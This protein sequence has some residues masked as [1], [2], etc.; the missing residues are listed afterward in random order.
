MSKK[1]NQILG[2]FNVAKETGK[3]ELKSKSE[4]VDLNLGRIQSE[5][6]QASKTFQLLEVQTKQSQ[7]KVQDLIADADEI[8]KEVQARKSKLQKALAEMED[9]GGRAY[10]EALKYEELA[11]KMME[12]D[13]DSKEPQR[14]ANEAMEI[15][16]DSLRR[17]DELEEIEQ[18]LSQILSNIKSI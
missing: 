5:Y 7:Q 8:K 2:K 10:D 18:D 6:Q 3:T 11:E 13:M 12:M 9:I 16:Q 1:V 4:K 14:K 15:N 17:R